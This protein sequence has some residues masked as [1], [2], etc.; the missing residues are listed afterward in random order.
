MR[1][2]TWGLDLSGSR[3]SAGGV[4]GLLAVHQAQVGGGAGSGGLDAGDY[5]YTHDAN[6]NVGQVINWSQDVT[7]PPS[8]DWDA[9]RLAAH[10]E[11]APFGGVLSQSGSYAAANP[12]RFSTKYWDD[13]TGLGYWLYRYYSPTLGRW[14]SRDP[15][16]EEGGVCLYTFAAN[17]PV[18]AIDPLGRDYHIPNAQEILEREIDAY[19]HAVSEA[20]DPLYYWKHCETSPQI[21]S[22]GQEIPPGY[23][24]REIKL[25]RWEEAELPIAPGKTASVPVYICD[26]VWHFEDTAVPEGTPCQCDWFV[27]QPC[28]R[29]CCWKEWG[30][31]SQQSCSEDRWE[32]CEL[33]SGPKTTGVTRRV[34]GIGLT[35]DCG[36]PS[37]TPK[38]CCGSGVS[39]DSLPEGIYDNP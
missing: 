13:E 24:I 5:V 34:S 26:E 15:I 11:Y 25:C 30:S 12:F 14:I 6:G 36:E 35:C 16:G 38:T 18:I 27:I 21:G 33:Y 2:Y 20:F 10:Y 1:K 17:S 31:G 37:G 39:L 29:T 22:D 3:G 8:N 23:L 7:S 9:S 19:V 4:G 32:A 28:T